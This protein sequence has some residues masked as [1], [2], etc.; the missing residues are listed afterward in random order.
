[1]GCATRIN[2]QSSPRLVHL[3]CSVFFWGA[4]GF[5]VI[6]GKSK[7]EVVEVWSKF[8]NPWKRTDNRWC[9]YI[10]C[11]KWMCFFL[12]LTSFYI[13]WM[14]LVLFFAGTSNRKCRDAAITWG[15][16]QDLIRLHTVGLE[17]NLS[18]LG[19]CSPNGGGG[20][21]C[22]GNHP[23][24]NARKN[25][26]SGSC[27]RKY[28]ICPTIVVKTWWGHLGL[29]GKPFSLWVSFNDW[30]AERQVGQPLGV[31]ISPSETYMRTFRFLC[32][33]IDYRWR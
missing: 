32:V 31:A 18:P 21:N 26:G 3:G 14:L 33:C 4:G 28:V 13:P 25:W 2:V 12:I 5:P 15:G 10:I 24:K 20:G 27:Y 23:Q 9:C 1:M 11:S 29:P 22:K 8:H 7:S 6:S 19:N 16:H 17:G 30:N